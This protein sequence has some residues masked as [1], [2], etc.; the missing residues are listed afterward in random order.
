MSTKRKWIETHRPAIKQLYD[1]VGRIAYKTYLVEDLPDGIVAPGLA[2][3]VSSVVVITSGSSDPARDWMSV[4]PL[5]VDASRSKGSEAPPRFVHDKDPIT[6]YFS[7]SAP[8]VSG[9]ISFHSDYDGRT[10]DIQPFGAPT[11][12]QGAVADL[13]ATFTAQ[14]G[15]FSEA[16]P[17]W[18]NA[19]QHGVDAFHKMERE[20]GSAGIPTFQADDDN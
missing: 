1:D 2:A 9:S 7:G 13:R 18:Q 3:K 12:L 19:L 20:L 6:F 8:S 4:V 15:S 16:D 10:Q 11:T 17:S 5:R 14:S